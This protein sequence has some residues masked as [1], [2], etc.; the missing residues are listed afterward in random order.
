MNCNL[1]PTYITP[2]I[3]GFKITRPIMHHK[4]KGG[5]REMSEPTLPFQTTDLL[6]TGRWSA[7][8][9]IRGGVSPRRRQNRRPQHTS[10]GIIST[11]IS[12]YYDI[13]VTSEHFT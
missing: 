8:L 10:C 5:M 4:I 12:Y 3:L 13:S 7:V 1:R 2:V 9:E 6:L 11:N